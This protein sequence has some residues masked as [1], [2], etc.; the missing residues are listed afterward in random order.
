MADSQRLAIRKNLQAALQAIS[1]ASGYHNDVK[2]TSVRRDPVYLLTVPPTE[3]PFFVL[4]ETDPLQR[5]FTPALGVEDHILVK[6]YAR[7]DSPGLDTSQKDDAFENLL[8]DIERALTVDITRG[9]NASDTRLHPAEAAAM[10]AANQPIVIL[11]Q[12]I[13]IRGALRIYGQP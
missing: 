7:V 1:R 9:G 8:A 11:S 13:E 10:G 5:V 3:L 4:G 12:A 6:L 2:A